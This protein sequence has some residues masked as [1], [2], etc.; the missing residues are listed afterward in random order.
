LANGSYDWP[1]ARIGKW[2]GSDGLNAENTPQSIKQRSGYQKIQACCNQ[3]ASDGFEY[4]W[5][6]T[7]CIDKRSSAE[8]SEAINSMYRWYQDCAVCYAYLADVPNDVD[9]TIQRRKFERSRWFTRG[10]TLQE[11][12]APSVLEFYGDQ[13]I[14]RGQGASLGTQRSLSDEISN[15]TGIPSPVLLREA[16]LSFYSIAQKMSWAAGRE[17][18]RVE[19]R[20]YSLMGLFNVNM[21]LLYG[22]GNRAFFRLQEELM[23]ISADETLFAWELPPLPDRSGY[24][25]ILAK[26]PDSFVHYASIDQRDSLFG[27]TQRTAPFAM[28]NMGLQLEVMLHKACDIRGSFCID[29]APYEWVYNDDLSYIIVLNCHNVDSK[30]LIGI[31]GKFSENIEESTPNNR[32]IRRCDSP[33]GGLVLLDPKIYQPSDRDRT[34]IFAETRGLESSESMALTE[35]GFQ[36]SNG[37]RRGPKAPGL[38]KRG[39]QIWRG[40]KQLPCFRAILPFYSIMERMLSLSSTTSDM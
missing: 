29:G 9:A 38:L 22:E 10:W 12:I 3:A 37:F 4:A 26:S 31:T 20:A 7:C 15:L 32:F 36:E 13:W 33:H 18:T 28:T 16:Q 8:L 39:P 24:P 1:I 35:S 2:E 34:T 5:V 27:S 25:G 40:L 11:L 19:D 21:P 14:S 23:K 30:S 6:D 17:T